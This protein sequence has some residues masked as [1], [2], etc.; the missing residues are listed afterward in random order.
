M[1]C[2]LTILLGAMKIVQS[3]Y[4]SARQPP[5][6]GTASRQ[7]YSV[8]IIYAR[9]T[10]PSPLSVP[11]P[12]PLPIVKP[13]ARCRNTSAFTWRANTGL[14]ALSLHQ[15]CCKLPVSPRCRNRSYVTCYFGRKPSVRNYVRFLGAHHRV[16]HNHKDVLMRMRLHIH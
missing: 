6:G 13:H 3:Q 16:W 2:A 12:L 4:F 14:V 1:R 8:V 5:R 10:S 7:M 9:T 11:F 15:A